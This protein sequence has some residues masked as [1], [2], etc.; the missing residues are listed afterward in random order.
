MATQFSALYTQPMATNSSA[1]HKL[2]RFYN[3]CMDTAELNDIKSDE[4]LEDLAEIG[5]QKKALDLNLCFIEQRPTLK[6][7]NIDAKPSF[8]PF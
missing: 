3:A 6:Q 4:L 5:E 1:I 8:A 2:K 7:N